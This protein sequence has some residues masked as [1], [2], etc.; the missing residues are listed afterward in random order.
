MMQPAEITI[1]ERELQANIVAF[2][3]MCGWLVY[4]TYDSRRSNRGFPDLLMVR[5]FVFVAIEV[6]TEKGKVS[7]HQEAWLAALSALPGAA[8]VGVVRPS[9]WFAG[10][11][12]SV[13]R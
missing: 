3:E 1:T 11:L 4:H 10:E 2:A 9:D 5:S 7:E 13:L 6:K 8:F 12:D